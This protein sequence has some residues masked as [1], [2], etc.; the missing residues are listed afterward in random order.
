MT[1]ATV[2]DTAPVPTPATMPTPT[3]PPA[4]AAS[5]TPT[6]L[7]APAPSP[8]PASVPTPAALRAPTAKQGS[9]PSKFGRVTEDGT[10]YLSAPEGEI[11]VGQ[12]AAGPPA[13]GLAFFGRK[14]DDLVVEIELV[15]R[16]LADGKAT[17]EQ[18]QGVLEKV[19]EALAARS[20]VGDIT[21]LES[22]CIA[23]DAAITTAR[24]A[25]QAQ[26]AEQRA[27]AAVAREALT[28]EAESLAGSTSWKATSERF[29]AMIDEWKSL[30]HADRAGEQAMWKRI[31]AARAQFDKARRAH[32]AE[33]DSERKIAVGRK[34]E[35]IAQAEALSTSTDWAGTGRKLRDLMTAWKDAPRSSKQDEDK[36]WKRFKAAQD[37]F[38]AAK[39]AAE[40]TQ[41]DAL[42]EHVPAKEA[43]VAEAEALLPITDVSA[44]KRALRSISERWE[45]IGD[46]PRADRD[47]LE[48]RLKKVEDA[49][50]GSE[51]ETWKRSNPETRA[52]A[53]STANAFTDGIAKLE[54]KRAK[55]LEKGDVAEVERIDASIAG[56]R[57]LLGAAEA[58]AA[59]FRG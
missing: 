53:E 19:R 1:E 15:S 16:R 38:Y 30:P 28:V 51:A 39:A 31:S 57:A 49:I 56:T 12:W 24:A 6:S 11:V 35:L 42:K 55:A 13:E 9:D 59:E 44:A 10:V 20:F 40:A 21:A 29:T 36:L 52:R 43:L 17:G 26:K 46:L 32:F 48:R 23:L 14:Y 2:P 27:R 4:P 58:A 25:A 22:R 8:T 45:K 7:A 37:L 34:R 3:S 18:A 41:E 47:R 54:A 5:P 33:L 50:R